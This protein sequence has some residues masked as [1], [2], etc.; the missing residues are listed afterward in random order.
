MVVPSITARISVIKRMLPDWLESLNKRIC[1]W[2]LLLQ[3][4]EHH[5]SGDYTL[6]VDPPDI[7]SGTAP[8]HIDQF[9][10]GSIGGGNKISVRIW[11]PHITC[12]VPLA[13]AGEKRARGLAGLGPGKQTGG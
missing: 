2:F 9:R 8:G 5:L 7:G 4:A 11:R 10:S 3:V 1:I 12:E 13:A 6:R